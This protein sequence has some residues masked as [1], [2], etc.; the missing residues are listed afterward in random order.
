MDWEEGR[1]SENV[2]DRRGFPIGVRGGSLGCGGLIL[3]LLISWITGVN[4]LQLLNMVQ[5]DSQPQVSAPSSSQESRPQGSR[6]QGSA[7]GDRLGRFASVVLAST[8]DVW[9]EIFAR[10]GR[11]YEKPKLVLFTNA[12]E[13]ACGLASTAVGPFYCEQDRKVY[14]DL[15][16]FQELSQRFGAS[17]D[18]ADAYVI[19]HEIGHHV[20][21]QLGLFDRVGGSRRDNAVSVRIELQ[22]DCY[23]G[24][25]GANA[26]RKSHMIDPGD[27][28]EGLRAAAAIGDDRLQRMQRGTVNPE[29]F[30]HGS[31][32]DRQ[33]WLR[34]GLETGDPSRCNTFGQRSD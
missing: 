13:S 28:E 14:L 15:S 32:Q 8:E 7:P 19:A 11:T 29:S 33:G 22:A 10:N 9:T 23:A 31:S 24:V 27:F 6:P 12:A 5:G 4:P 26:N 25:W 1:E 21:N 18:F 34:R 20:Q 3:L 30:T 2:E 17:G 16:F